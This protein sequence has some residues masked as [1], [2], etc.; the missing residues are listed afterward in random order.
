MEYP[1]YAAIVSLAVLL[2]CPVRAEV[3]DQVMAEGMERA[4]AGRVAQERIDDLAGQTQDL[5]R[6][7][8]QLGRIID[9]LEVYNDLLQRQVEAQEAELAD[10]RRA[11]D[12]VAIIERQVVPLMFRMIDALEEFVRLDVPFLPDER[13]AR[14]AGLRELMERA[15]VLPAEKF[16]RVLEAYQVEIEYGRTIE[17]Y[18][19]RVDIDG[20]PHEVDFLRIGRI[21]L[22]YQDSSGM[23]TGAWDQRSGQWRRLTEE[24]YRRET[25]RGLRMARKQAAPDLLVLPVPAP[26]EVAP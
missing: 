9:G 14:I 24:R 20:R 19:G 18:Q 22:L 23:Y 4:V 7:Y 1:R 2:L 11:S 3:V 13:Q 17:A 5:L 10:L 6:E 25:A 16:R 21:A 8:R 12:E 15:D 26:G